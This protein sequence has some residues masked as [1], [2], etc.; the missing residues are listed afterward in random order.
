VQVLQPGVLGLGQQP[1]GGDVR[2]GQGGGGRRRP[3]GERQQAGERGA[4]QNG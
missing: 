3:D 2:P 1:R 4:A